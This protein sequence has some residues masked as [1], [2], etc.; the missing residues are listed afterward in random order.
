MAL[1]PRLRF[2]DYTKY[3]ADLRTDLP[4]NYTLTYSW[5]ERPEAAEQL[6][7]YA[8]RGFN[9]AVV[10]NVAKGHPLPARWRGREVVAGT[11]CAGR[12]RSEG[13]KIEYV[14]LDTI[15]TW[16]RN[17]KRHAADAQDS[18]ISRFGF[19]A[20]LLRDARS[21]MLVA[22][23]GRLEA[24]KRKKA[25]GE[26]P[27]DRVQIAPG[28]EWLAPV[29]AGV[30]FSSDTER[31]AYA[32]AD[33]RLCEAGGWEDDKL[34]DIL[35]RHAGDGPE[36]LRGTGY[37]EGDLEMMA[38]RLNPA[39]FS[40]PESPEEFLGGGE[41]IGPIGAA[42]GLRQI[43]LLY[44]PPDFAR[45]LERLERVRTR[46]NIPTNTEAITWLLEQA[47]APSPAA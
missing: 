42:E 16:P 44:N 13:V 19:V 5:S 41:V 1:F 26:A 46:Q 34:L 23:H 36:A 6:G 7:A 9:T 10:F 11:V 4:P 12:S 31:E 43:I 14:S 24:L 35:R 39:E 20:P 8:K 21:G 38:A 30:S 25:A 18:S 47:A 37:D 28:G 3:P 2:Y 27:P 22:G 45:V 15:E 40:V 33:N 29:I 32:L 17:P